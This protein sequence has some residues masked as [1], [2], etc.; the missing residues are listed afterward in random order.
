VVNQGPRTNSP[1]LDRRCGACGISLLHDEKIG[2][3]MGDP[4][5]FFCST[6]DCPLMSRPSSPFSSLEGDSAGGYWAWVLRDG[7]PVATVYEP[8]LAERIVEV[9]NEDRA[10]IRE[11]RRILLL[12]ARVEREAA[13]LA[14]EERNEGDD[15]V[16][17]IACLNDFS[18]RSGA[19]TAYRRAARLIRPVRQ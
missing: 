17:Y 10:T 9:L 11:A 15:D 6:P 14:L 1:A 16:W 12:A 8:G 4:G 18:E 5:G 7:E 19:A 3:R 2:K 13:D